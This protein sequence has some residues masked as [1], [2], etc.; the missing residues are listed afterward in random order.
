MPCRAIPVASERGACPGLVYSLCQVAEVCYPAPSTSPPNR[1]RVEDESEDDPLSGEALPRPQSQ[2]HPGVDDHREEGESKGG[3]GG[4]KPP[5]Y[6]LCP[7][8]GA[9]PRASGS[10][11]DART[12]QARRAG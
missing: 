1:D 7:A 11:A 9:I 3:P 12:A 2:G 5:G 6:V 4:G 8:S 10:A